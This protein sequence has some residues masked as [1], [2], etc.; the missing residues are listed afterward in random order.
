[1]NKKLRNRKLEFKIPK[2]WI[3]YDVELGRLDLTPKKDPEE[4]KK[5]LEDMD[6]RVKEFLMETK[7]SLDSL[8]DTIEFD[9]V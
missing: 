6:R 5:R 7:G 1:M 4:D 3:V 9:D 8:E 2:K